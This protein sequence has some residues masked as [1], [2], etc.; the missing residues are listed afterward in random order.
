[1]KPIVLH[2]MAKRD[3]VV[4]LSR[5]TIC[6]Y[7]SEPYMPAL[8]ISVVLL[9]VAGMLL[10]FTH[11]FEGYASGVV[12]FG[13]LVSLASACV[14]SFRN[15][16]PKKTERDNT[17]Y[18]IVMHL[19]DGDKQVFDFRSE[20]ICDIEYEALADEFESSRKNYLE[21]DYYKSLKAQDEEEPEQENLL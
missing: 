18:R 4:G 21:I 15:L 3:H 9:L 12:L 10:F 14:V 17:V 1:L 6:N 5:Q 8:A 20:N 11:L 7:H 2:F 19:A 13:A 16:R